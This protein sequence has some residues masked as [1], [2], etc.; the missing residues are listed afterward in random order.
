MIS[1]LRIGLLRRAAG[2]RA[3]LTAL[4]IL[5][6]A[7]MSACE[8][9]SV[10]HSASDPGPVIANVNGTPLYKRDFDS[11][12]PVDYQRALTS[13]ERREFLDRWITTQLL[14]DAAE[15]R[16]LGATAEIESRMEQLKKDLVADQLV[17]KIV[18]ERAIVSDSDVRSYYNARKD[19]YT[20]EY[21]VSHIVVGSL[22]DAEEVKNQ[23]KKRTFSWVARHHSLDKHT[24]V[25]GDLGFLSKGNMIPE[26]ENVVFDMQVGEVSD[27]IESDFGYHLIKLAAVRDARNKLEYEEA[28]EEISRLLLLEKRAAVYDSLIAAIRSQAKIEIMDN[29]LRAA[30]ER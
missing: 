10:G 30:G 21:R 27:V 11:Y 25:G 1:H 24:G 12:L 4:L 23:L 9:R 26:F 8:R 18:R 14:Y 29:E 2:A 22:E 15:G 28:A 13:E 6:A 5:A 19:E 17:Q 3:P 16:G 7:L 20:K